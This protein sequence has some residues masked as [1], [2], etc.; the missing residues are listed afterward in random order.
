MEKMREL[1]AL[2]E[3]NVSEVRGALRRDLAAAGD[4]GSRISAQWIMCHVLGFSKSELEV[5][6]GRAVA[7]DELAAIKDLASRRAAGEPLQYLTGRAPFRYLEL[8]ARPGVFIPRPETEVLVDTALECIDG[9]LGHAHDGCGHNDGHGHDHDDARSGFCPEDRQGL[10]DAD[11]QDA[12]ATPG[13]PRV[14]V[15]DL[16]CGSGTV[17]V[18][19][20]SERESAEVTAVDISPEAAA[21]TGENAAEAGVSDRVRVLVGDLYAPLGPGERFE[22]VVA[23]PPYIP[24][25]KLATMPREVVDWEPMAALDGG[26]D[27]LDA[28]RRILDGLPGRLERGGHLACELD[29]DNVVEAARMC[30]A[31]TGELEFSEVDV[32]YDLTDR[33]R[34]LLVRR[35]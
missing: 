23:N 2:E 33:P 19:V 21:L 20:A 35:A 6:S 4:A 17:A 25:A 5:Q 30:A 1:G 27:G 16:C 12:D 18:S 11:A 10:V 26:P 13:R 15:L 3:A 28:F 9:V 8:A 22:L 34:V 7:G 24:S 32:L 31:L 29:E 14:R